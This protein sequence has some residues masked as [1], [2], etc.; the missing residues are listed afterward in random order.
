MPK[1]NRSAIKRAG[2]AEKKRLRNAHIKSTMKT[3]I[4]KL[5]VAMEKKNKEELN[6]AFKKAVAFISKA[7]SKGVIHKNNAAR[8]ISRLSKRVHTLS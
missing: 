6:D 5:T 2:Q 3:Y 7:S 1:K 4:K 8:K